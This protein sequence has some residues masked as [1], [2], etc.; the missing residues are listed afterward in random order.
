MTGYPTPSEYQEALQFPED[1][2]SDDALQQAHPDE[3]MLGLPRAITGHFAAVFPMTA[4]TG[5]RWA[6]KCFFT[7][8]TDQQA[9]YD[10]IAE[11]LAAH[12][13]PHMVEFEYQPRGVQVEGTAY[14]IVKMQW[15]DGRP[16]NRFVAEHLDAPDTL[17]A[18]A[19]AWTSLVNT[20]EEHNMAH[21]DLQH[22]NVL[23]EDHPGGLGLTLVDYDTMYVPALDGKKSPEVGHRNYQHPDRTERDFGPKLDRFAALVIYTALQGCRHRPDLWD[24]YDTGENMLFRAGDFYDPE[25]SPLIEDLR[26]VQPVE[27]LVDAIE[28]ACQ[29]APEAVPALE[30]VQ[31]ASGVASWME[32]VQVALPRARTRDRTM[33]RSRFARWFLPGS[34]AIVGTAGGLAALGSPTVAL[35]A[36]GTALIGGGGAAAYRYQQLSVVRRR[37]RLDQE[38]A[39]ID[40]RIA[41]LQRRVDVLQEKR[42]ATKAS[43][44]ERRAERLEE[45]REEALY[46]RLKYHFIGEARSVDGITHKG[47]VRLKAAGIRTAYAATPERLAEVTGISPADRTRLAQWRASLVQ[48][49]AD[50]IPTTLSPAEER[51]VQRYVERRMGELESRIKRARDMIRVQEEERRQ[52][53][54]RRATMPTLSAG[55]YLRYLL[56]LGTLPRPETPPEPVSTPPPGERSPAMAK[57]D[58]APEPADEVP[59][60]EERQ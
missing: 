14:P 7:D 38:M 10:R 6:V 47:V 42:A 5:E 32:S 15:A 8:A 43:V 60:W 11:H 35:A 50:D 45:L 55:R 31:D 29:V 27:S 34:G 56:R 20:L 57:A 17:A 9:R 39:R 36:L 3:N 30:A 33:E 49:Y 41:S 44:E 54:E 53:E 1:A 13:L 46:D 18:L 2:F 4:S 59:W 12:S 24:R 48:Q 19:E 26:T 23:V 37:R 25:S 52:V 28:R 40:A 22:G 16:L 58:P 21:G 51:R